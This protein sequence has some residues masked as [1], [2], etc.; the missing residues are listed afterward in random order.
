MFY[1]APA[2][3][4]GD[5]QV[6]IFGR[7]AIG[8]SARRTERGMTQNNTAI[9]EVQPTWKY[10]EFDVIDRSASSEQNCPQAMARR[11]R[12]IAVLEP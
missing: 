11:W 12:T 1:G 9:Y 8:A 10:A 5:T 3:E 2:A 7:V 6:G 4:G